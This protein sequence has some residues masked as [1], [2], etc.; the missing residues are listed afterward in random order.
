MILFLDDEQRKM[1]SHR[2]ELEKAGYE[3]EY[4]ND[5]DRAL[6]FFEK[7]SAAIDLV[8]L[9]IMMPWGKS[10]TKEETDYGMR[11]G[12]LVFDRIR[13]LVP[14]VK[15]LVL[16]NVTDDT[17]LKVLRNKANCQVASKQDLLVEDFPG[18]VEDFKRA[19]STIDEV[20]R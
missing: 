12:I 5:V 19:C 6:L 4:L 17:V 20:P 3:V 1:D 15:V 9:D 18:V 16:T 10:F 14:D 8:I 11:T 7:N 2:L 13:A